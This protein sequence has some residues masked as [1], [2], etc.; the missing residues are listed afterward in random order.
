MKSSKDKL[1]WALQFAKSNGIN[2]LTNKDIGWL[3]DHLGIGIPTGHITGAFN[4]A[5]GGGYANRSTQ[6]KTIRITE[7]GTEYLKK[8]SG[9]EL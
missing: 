2:G 6:D 9:S 3:T 8:S 4:G 1:L 7:V 5:K